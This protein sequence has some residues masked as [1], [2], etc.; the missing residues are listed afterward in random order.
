MDISMGSSAYHSFALYRLNIQT[1]A[2][3]G[4]SITPT[5]FV[6]K[7][8]KIKITYST[9]GFVLDSIYFNGLYD[10]AVTHDSLTSYTFDNVQTYSIIK[11]V[12]KI[13]TFTISASA[14]VGGNINPS[15]NNIIN[16]DSSILYN[17]NANDTFII[18]SV[19][20]NGR[21]FY[22]FTNGTQAGISQ[23]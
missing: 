15:G 5:T 20:I 23:L 9:T 14:G 19:F 6:R 16:Y 22:N 12:Y 13:K 3:E 7:G 10:S 1:S 17:I 8:D 21:L 2:N 11:V 4:G 18:D